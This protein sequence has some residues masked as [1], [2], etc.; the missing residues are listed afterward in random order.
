MPN[1]DFHISAEEQVFQ[2]MACKPY[3]PTD[4][5]MASVAIFTWKV[6]IYNCLHVLSQ[7]FATYDL[8]N[9][10]IASWGEKKPSLRPPKHILYRLL[11]AKCTYPLA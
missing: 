5:T 11:D 3:L 8:L 6:I 9:I 2:A 4:N 7:W 10:G 1:L